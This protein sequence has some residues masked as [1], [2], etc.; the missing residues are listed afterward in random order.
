MRLKEQ[1]DLTRMEGEDPSMVEKQFNKSKRCKA[2]WHLA[3]WYDVLLG[4]YTWKLFPWFIFFLANIYEGFSGQGRYEKQKKWSSIEKE[5]NRKAGRSKSRLKAAFYFSWRE[6]SVKSSTSLVIELYKT[7]LWGISGI[8][9][10]L[11]TAQ[12]WLTTVP[13]SARSPTSQSLCPAS[14]IP[15]SL[16]SL[17][18]PLQ[19]EK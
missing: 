2:R 7:F 13:L 1:V 9:L 8:L 18:S 17:T 11:M 14:N 10:S 19:P 4:M 5:R 15:S 6:I 3:L 16:P 12:C